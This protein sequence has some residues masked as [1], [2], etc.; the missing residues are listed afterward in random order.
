MDLNPLTPATD[1][2]RVAAYIWPDQPDRLARTR[3]AIAVATAPVDRA[4]AIDWLPARLAEPHPGQLHLV[5]HT[6][7]WQYLPEA[8][9]QKGEAILARAGARATEDAP[10]ARF[11]MEPDDSKAPGAALTLTTWPGGQTTPMGRVDFHG[12][13]VDWQPAAA[14]LPA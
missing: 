14:I 10:L 13:W 1:P 5:F 3:A 8:A 12:R 11:Q 6:I 4:D 2:T 9:K 7:A